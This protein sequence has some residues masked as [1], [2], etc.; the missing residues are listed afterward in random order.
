M[1]QRATKVVAKQRAS[2]SSAGGPFSSPVCD[3]AMAGKSG[4]STAKRQKSFRR[5]FNLFGT[6][7]KSL[8]ELLESQTQD[9][10]IARTAGT[11]A[12]CAPAL[13]PDL[14][15]WAGADAT[16]ADF[17]AQFEPVGDAMVSV[18]IDAAVQGLKGE[19]LCF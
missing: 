16:A 7:G 5:R 1:R 19:N 14:A 4:R 17:E 9:S 12:S 2:C 6:K 8:E 13:F 10:A 11:L 18:L 3:S 15:A